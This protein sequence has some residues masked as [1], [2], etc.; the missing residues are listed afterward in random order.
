[1]DQSSLRRLTSDGIRSFLP[2]G[3]RDAAEW[4]WDRTETTGDGR[5]CPLARMLEGLSLAFEDPGHVDGVKV[6]RIDE[7]LFRELDAV[8]TAPT[9][10]EGALLGRR[11]REE[12]DR[13]L[14]SR[15]AG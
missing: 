5:F 1:L 10:E 3:L 12:S 4:C 11:L 6:D 14:G 9:A 15:H 8:L 7:L 2:T 13:P